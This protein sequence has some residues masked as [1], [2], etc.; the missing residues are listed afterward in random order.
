M[1][2]SA[3]LKM[4]CWGPDRWRSAVGGKQSVMLQGLE[5]A[6]FF[7]LAATPSIKLATARC[8]IIA[9]SFFCYRGG[10][11]VED[12]IL[13][14]SWDG[15][16]PTPVEAFGVDAIQRRRLR[17]CYPRPMGSLR[18]PMQSAPG[19]LLPPSEDHRPLRRRML[20][21]SSTKW[22]VPGGRCQAG[23][24]SEALQ[25]RRRFGTRLLFPFSSEVPNVI[26]KGLG[27]ISFFFEALLV[28]TA[29]RS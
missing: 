18:S 7:V 4:A 25:R 21:R 3:D 1:P 5:E 26:S 15:Y 29:R 2:T 24:G 16:G 19:L 6:V 17:R 20:R 23:G 11:V 8:V 9:S 14:A 22:F 27:V 13:A 28:R 12:G 10:G